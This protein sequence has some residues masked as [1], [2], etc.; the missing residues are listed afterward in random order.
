[1]REVKRTVVN[2]STPRYSYEKIEKVI[3][4]SEPLEEKGKLQE[5]SHGT[6]LENEDEVAGE[7]T[8][9]DR[10]KAEKVKVEELGVGSPADDEPITIKKLQEQLDGLFIKNDERVIELLNNLA[11]RFIKINSDYEDELTPYN[12][13]LDKIYE[14]LF[15]LITS[16]EK[17]TE[18]DIENSLLSR[19]GESSDVILEP[20]ERN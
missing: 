9:I 5:A 13:E 12:T 1:M 16:M 17:D 3:P 8:K 15:D 10:T 7:D 6:A 4:P 19:L 20:S 11:D 2:I 18:T 14:A